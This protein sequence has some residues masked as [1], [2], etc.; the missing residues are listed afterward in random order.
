MY[1]SSDLLPIADGRPALGHVDE[2]PVVLGHVAHARAHRRQRRR[3]SD[4]AGVHRRR[5]RV[6]YLLAARWGSSSLGGCS[7][8]SVGLLVGGRDARWGRS[9]SAR[10]SSSSIGV[11]EAAERGGG[12][13]EG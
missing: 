8:S 4:G 7:S 12:I 11:L 6:R 1:G 5:A 3:S 2:Q 10:S 9:S 13:E